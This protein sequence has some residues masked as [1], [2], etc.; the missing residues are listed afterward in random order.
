MSRALDLVRRWCVRLGLLMLGSAVLGLV[1]LM[2]GAVSS[3]DLAIGEQSGFRTLAEIAVI[4]C[5]LAAIGYWN[6]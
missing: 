5:L 1:G 4:G 3:A 6:E 2:I